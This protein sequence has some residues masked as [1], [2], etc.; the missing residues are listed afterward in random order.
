MYSDTQIWAH[1]SQPPGNDEVEFFARLG[2]APRVEDES[3]C[4][5]IIVSKRFVPRACNLDFIGS[6]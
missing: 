1:T 2:V 3:K 5:Q 6:N 4:I